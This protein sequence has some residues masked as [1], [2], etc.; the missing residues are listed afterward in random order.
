MSN[1]DHP[2]RTAYLH[3]VVRTVSPGYAAREW[4]LNARPNHSPCDY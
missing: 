1:N 3:I 2:V 4:S